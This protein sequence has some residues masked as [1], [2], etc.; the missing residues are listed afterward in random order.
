MMRYE[1]RLERNQEQRN[2][3]GISPSIHTLLVLRTNAV[4]YQKQR[5]SQGLVPQYD[6]RNEIRD[7]KI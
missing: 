5:N 3:Q 7:A 4:N 1:K 6:D 2:S